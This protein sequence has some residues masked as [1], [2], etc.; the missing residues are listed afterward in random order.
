MPQAARGEFVADTLQG[1]SVSLRP[2][3]DFGDAFFQAR[4]KKLDRGRTSAFM[5]GNRGFLREF[6]ARSRISF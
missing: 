4:L 6:S 5:M 2:H 1:A 3:H